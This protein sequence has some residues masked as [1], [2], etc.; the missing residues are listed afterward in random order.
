MVMNE[1]ATS[2]DHYIIRI[3]SFSEELFLVKKNSE[4]LAFGGFQILLELC[5]P[6]LSWVLDVKCTGPRG[7]SRLATLTGV[8]SFRCSISRKDGARGIESPSRPCPSPMRPHGSMTNVPPPGR[9]RPTLPW[10]QPLI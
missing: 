7:D 2:G 10:T 3:L 8:Q 6:Y 1:A 5:R 9:A 4:F